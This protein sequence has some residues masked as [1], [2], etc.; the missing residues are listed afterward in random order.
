MNKSHI[1][2]V[3]DL[4]FGI[5]NFNVS[6]FEEQMKFF[7]VQFFPYLI[8]N[9]IKEVIF[10]GD[11][12]H[13]REKIDWYI[14]DTL[15]DRFFK[16]FDDNNITLHALVGNHDTY[17]KDQIKQNSLTK[18]T[19]EYKNIIVYDEPKVK[20][21]RKYTFV[22]E[23]WIVNTKT[24]KF[25]N[26]GDIMIGHLELKG[27][28]MMKGITAKSG[29]EHTQ[30]SKYKYVFSGHYHVNCERD[31]VIMIGTPYQLTWN[32]FN[33][34]KGFYVLDDEYNYTFIENKVNPKY[35]KIFYNEGE[36]S[37]D[38]LGE[39]RSITKE[40]SLEIAKS[41]YCRIYVKNSVDM[42][43][44]ETYQTSLMTVSCNHHKI[45]MIH[46]QDVVL[47]F[48]SSSFDESFAEEESTLE[49]VL[50]CIKGM[51]FESHIDN[52]LMCDL[53]ISEYK[54]AVDEAFNEGDEV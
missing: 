4:H 45:D 30:F 53:A 54:Q 9:D 33:T 43:A 48:D 29:Y 12:F 8:E 22:F 49:L 50:A 32:D 10:S 23:P 11:F 52:E 35:V 15:K 13:S 36:L 7:E 42:L 47:D 5:G 3:T 6:L 37:I 2:F 26:T 1:A 25:Q 16:W 20:Q 19:N 18:T 24:H 40:E 51:T 27:F 17:Y 21:I 39:V 14:L 46:L 38:G 44:L 31:N 34:S 41:N 28:P